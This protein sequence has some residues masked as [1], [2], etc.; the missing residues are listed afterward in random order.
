MTQRG[1]VD[2]ADT[3]VRDR[4]SQRVEV[5]GSGGQKV[6]HVKDRRSWSEGRPVGFLFVGVDW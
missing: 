1:H 3:E 6:N 2:V 5:Q 4:W